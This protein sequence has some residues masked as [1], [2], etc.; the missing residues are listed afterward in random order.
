MV[1]KH[2]GGG[3]KPGPA[4]THTSKHVVSLGGLGQ[5]GR[6]A[7]PPSV[8]C[9]P[10]SQDFLCNVM[11][12][13]TW[14]LVSA[15]AVCFSAGCA[16][17]Q[18][19]NCTPGLCS[20]RSV[21]IMDR[22]PQTVAAGRMHSLRTAPHDCDPHSAPLRLYQTP[23]VKEQ[24]LRSKG[25]TGAV[26]RRVPPFPQPHLCSIRTLLRPPTERGRPGGPAWEQGWE[27]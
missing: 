11:M 25:G 23:S 15:R 6:L 19:P 4:P 1:W 5:G 16:A 14:G 3:H 21:P 20:P 7:Q 24:A 13:L 2:C 12:C 18:A 9:G 17:E 10:R 8:V 22:T 26:R 27:T